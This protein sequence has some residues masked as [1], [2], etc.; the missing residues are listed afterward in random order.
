MN[1]GRVISLT[2]DLL[3]AVFLILII[4]DLLDEGRVETG[5]KTAIIATAAI[6][7]AIIALWQ[8]QIAWMYDGWPVSRPVAFRWVVASFFG[9]AAVLVTWRVTV[10]L[11]PDLPGRNVIAPF[12]WLTFVRSVLWFASRWLTVAETHEA[13]PGETGA[14]GAN[15]NG[16]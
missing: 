4:D 5:T 16:G 13:G 3:S 10:T 11:N 14:G 9:M 15:G 12:V 2:S 8:S 6:V 1:R 7:F